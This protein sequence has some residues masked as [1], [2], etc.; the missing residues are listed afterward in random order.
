MAR[1]SIRFPEVA[2]VVAALIALL[3]AASPARAQDSLKDLLFGDKPAEGQRRAPPPPAPACKAG[4]ETRLPGANQP[5]VAAAQP[6]TGL[7]A[8]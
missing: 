7:A 5:R 6:A 8:G 2:V 3:M 4:P 1:T